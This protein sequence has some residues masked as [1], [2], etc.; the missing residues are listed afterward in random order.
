[1]L[2][3]VKLLFGEHEHGGEEEQ[4]EECWWRLR[5]G[6]S[7]HLLMAA[8]GGRGRLEKA[9]RRRERFLVIDIDRDCNECVEGRAP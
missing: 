4:E 3:R 6:V 1:M 8:R 7:L 5:G 9:R 2:K